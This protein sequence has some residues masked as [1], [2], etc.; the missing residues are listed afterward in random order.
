MDAKSFLDNFTTIADAPGGI[1]RLR[2]LAL[3]LAVLGRLVE[4]DSTDDSA[5]VG[6]ASVRLEKGDTLASSIRGGETTPRVPRAD[7]RDGH[8]PDGW[9]WARI[10]DTGEY[11]NGLAF[12]NSDW[13]QSG[14]PII[15]IQNLTNPAV[16]FN[17]ADGPFPDDRMAHDG[18]ILVSWSATLNA[19]RWNRGDGVV[20]QHI[21]KVIP[22]KRVVTPDFLFHLLRH[23]IRV[24]AESEAAHGLVMQHIN[25]GPF[26]TYVV[27]VPPIFEQ[28]RIVAKVDELMGLCDELATRQQRR[29]RANA[30]FR[31]SALH[32]LTEAATPADLRQAW[33]RASTNWPALTQRRDGI[34]DL[35]ETIVQLAVEGRLVRQESHDEPAAMILEECCR[36][37]ADLVKA[38]GRSR[39]DLEPVSDDD[40]PF[41]VPAGWALARLDLWCD[42]GGG[43][44]KGR[45]LTNRATT[46]LPYLRVANVK[47]GYLALDEV[48]LIEVPLDEVDRYSLQAGDVLLTEGGDWDKLG[49]SAIWTGE[50]DPCLHQ[51]HVFRARTLG[52]GPRPEWISLFTNSEAGRTYFQSKA[53]R[54][55]NL[56]SI[57]MTELRSMPLPVPPLAE[58]DRILRRVAEMAVALDDVEASLQRRD[59][60]QRAVAACLTATG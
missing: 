46:T 49:R 57:N 35:R 42:I 13:K 25:R 33:E 31:A 22:D 53:K 37:K 59:D 55:T 3:D 32:A 44:A 17:Y 56:A 52:S 16:P 27:A 1:Q 50:I 4:Q 48:K 39:S 41:K 7:E 2:D 12:T 21:F 26:L 10:D 24:M 43:L 29:Q 18:D 6:L 5:A 20:N 40:L 34:L 11:V 60:A 58:Q 9:K 15:R 54:T 19:F 30:R 51:N 8:L 14:V 23:S 47:A 36:R 28:Q 38:G 45:K